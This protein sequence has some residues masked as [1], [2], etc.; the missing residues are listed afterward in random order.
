MSGAVAPPRAA[1]DFVRSR[2]DLHGLTALVTGATSGIGY[3]IAEAFVRAGADVYVHGRGTEKAEAAARRIGAR[4]VACDLSDASEIDRLCDRLLDS[5][6]RLDIIVNNAGIEFPAALPSL[7]GEVL[8]A[9]FTVNTFA[10]V[11]VARRLLPLLSRSRN[12]SILNVSSI[13]DRVPSHS[14]AAYAASK[15]ALRRDC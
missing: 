9:T 3:A 10:P 13:H 15:A 6:T 8:A 11:Q 12:G 4:A 2:F 1:D 14:N 7:T 5:E